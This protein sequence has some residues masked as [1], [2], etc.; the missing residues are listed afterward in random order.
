MKFV[1]KNWRHIWVHEEHK[2]HVTVKNREQG[3]RS[4][5]PDWHCWTLSTL[6]TALIYIHM[7]MY[8]YE[9]GS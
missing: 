1:A 4:V 6:F 9:I 7:Y 8:V 2:E 5:T 3:A